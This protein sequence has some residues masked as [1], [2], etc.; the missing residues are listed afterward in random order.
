METEANQSAE[1][2]VYK[3]DFGPEGNGMGHSKLKQS[4]KHETEVGFLY[5]YCSFSRLLLL[6]SSSA[7]LVHHME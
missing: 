4:R 6:H 5:G 1:E 2:S 7:F 3:P